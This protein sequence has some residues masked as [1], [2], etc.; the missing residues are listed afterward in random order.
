MALSV[1]LWKGLRLLYIKRK[2][3]LYKYNILHNFFNSLYEKIS[4][5]GIVG[6]PSSYGGF[7]TLVD[8]LIESDDG[9]GC[10]V[11]AIVTRQKH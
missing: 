1:F 9:L 2:L 8:Q 3:N 5:I 10:I 6:V 4:V 11:Q 7:E